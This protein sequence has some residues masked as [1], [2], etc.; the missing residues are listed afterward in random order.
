MAHFVP[1]SK[2]TSREETED[3]F[4]DNV[5][6]LHDLPDDVTSDQGP[7]FISHFRRQL[8]Q[9]FG[10]SAYISTTYHPQTD[11]QTKRFNQILEQYLRCTISYQQEDWVDFLA[12]AEFA[13]NNSIHASTKVTPF[14]ANY[15]FHPHFNIFIPGI[16]VNPSADARTSQDVHRDLSL[17][18][19]IVGEQYKDQ[20]DRHRLAALPFTIGDMV[21]LLCRHIATTLPYAKL[22]YK[23]LGPF[24]I[25]EPINL[26]AF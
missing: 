8:L 22:D 5:I 12:M 23:T 24:R 26:V 3:L 6:G 9:T 20:A 16:F 13:Y 25:I 10:T 15:G 2:T 11:G 7:Q 14:F 19:R 1:G 18:L 21:W 4:L 17:E